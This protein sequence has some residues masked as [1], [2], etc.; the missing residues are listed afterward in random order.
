VEEL[1]IE[2]ALAQKIIVAAE[3]AAKAATAEENPT[4]AEG[5]IK[6]DKK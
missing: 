5:M 1:E 2:A 4:Q 3:E 6:Q